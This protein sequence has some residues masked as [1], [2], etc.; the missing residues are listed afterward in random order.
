M[1]A[2]AA[3]ARLECEISW[4]H[5]AFEPVLQLGKALGRSRGRLALA[6]HDLVASAV[7]DH[8]GRL[9]T[10]SRR[11][12]TSQERETMVSS[13]DVLS[14]RRRAAR[15]PL[16]EVCFRCGDVEMRGRLV[17]KTAPRLSASGHGQL[18]TRLL[19]PPE[20]GRARFLPRK[21]ALSQPIGWPAI[22]LSTPASPRGLEHFFVSRARLSKRNIVVQFSQ[23]TGRYPAMQNPSRARSDGSYWRGL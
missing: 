4:R 2:A 7:S 23:R 12:T 21:W 17:Q 11:S 22:K 15:Q 18:G 9:S 20:R 1:H 14:L 19:L 5:L 10:S 3:H 8:T 6:A 16:K 13:D